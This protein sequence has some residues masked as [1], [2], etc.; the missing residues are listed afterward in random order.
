MIISIA[1]RA[2]ARHSS[3]SPRKVNSSATAER[4]TVRVQ[5]DA[6]SRWLTPSAARRGPGSTWPAIHPSP[7]H[8][9][10]VAHAANLFT[11]RVRGSEPKEPIVVEPTLLAYWGNQRWSGTMRASLFVL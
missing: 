7:H 4:P 10:R 3:G 11:E 6:R 5:A 1:S 9:P 8:D 2:P